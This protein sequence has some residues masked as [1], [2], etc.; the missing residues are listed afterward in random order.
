VCT[1]ATAQTSE[2]VVADAAALP[3]F[4]RVEKRV[5]FVSLGKYTKNMP[6][7]EIYQTFFILHDSLLPS[8]STSFE[9]KAF[10]SCVTVLEMHKLYEV[11]IASK[12]R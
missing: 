3:F 8:S 12:Q 1:T 11:F 9:R 7:D 6:C 5:A 10:V 4:I 2:I